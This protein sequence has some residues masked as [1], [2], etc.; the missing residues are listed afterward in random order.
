MIGMR[1]ALFSMPVKIIDVGGAGG[2]HP[3]WGPSSGSSV[4]ALFF[5]PEH[6][7]AARLQ[8]QGFGQVSER[9]LSD[10]EGERQLYV[11]SKPECSS[12]HHP[13]LDVLERFP[14]STR[15]S[16]KMVTK[17]Q[18]VTLDDEILRLGFDSPDFLKMDVQGHEREVL[19]GAS[20]TLNDVIGVES[21]VFFIDLYKNAT[22]FGDLAAVLEPKGFELFDLQR[23]YWKRS[24]VVRYRRKGQLVSGNA[25]FFLPPE[26]V[27]QRFG[28]CEAKLV[29]AFRIFCTYRKYDV[30]GKFLELLD[31]VELKTRLEKVLDPLA[32]FKE[33][34]FGGLAYRLCLR[35]LGWVP[36]YLLGGLPRSY[37]R[38]YISGDEDL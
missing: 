8:E 27:C 30:A 2:L 25:L 9:G 36:E 24:Q 20:E 7:G 19:S 12:F 28:D 1:Q 22:G 15:F 32:G 23:V 18:V 3:R 10:H 13:N 35:H 5:E 31:D 26:T 16:T 33:S 4:S 29:A 37:K 17:V 38:W 21:E 34:R 14:Q 11:T 6:N